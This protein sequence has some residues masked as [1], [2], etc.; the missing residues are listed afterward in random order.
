MK[1]EDWFEPPQKSQII[2]I[3]ISGKMFS[4]HTSPP[5]GTSTDGV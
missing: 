2:N 5:Y 3:K 1:N 4:D